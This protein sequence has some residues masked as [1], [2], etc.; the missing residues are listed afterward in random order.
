MFASRVD[1]KKTKQWKKKFF[2]ILESAF[3]SCVTEKGGPGGQNYIENDS[4]VDH[5]LNENEEKRY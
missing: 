5:Q 3:L 2:F 1:V 4:Q